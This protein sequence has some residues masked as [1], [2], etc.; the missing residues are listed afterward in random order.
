MTD[1]QVQTPVATEDNLDT[2]F[3]NV[4]TLKE[5]I[6]SGK[7]TFFQGDNKFIRSEIKATHVEFLKENRLKNPTTG[8]YSIEPSDPIVLQRLNNGV[9]QIVDGNHR[10]KAILE[11]YTESDKDDSQF[12]SIAFQLY[13]RELSQ[14]EVLFLQVR[15]NDSTERHSPREIALAVIS[16]RNLLMS[17]FSPEELKSRKVQKT[18]SDKIKSVFGIKDSAI[19]NYL[20]IYENQDKEGYPEI[21]QM[22][23]NGELDYS[24]ALV[25]TQRAK[26]ASWNLTK[27]IE[28]FKSVNV[29]N[30]KFVSPSRAATVRWLDKYA[31]DFLKKEKENG[32]SEGEENGDSEGGSVK[33]IKNTETFTEKDMLD[34]LNGFL[35]DEFIPK[36]LQASGTDKTYKLLQSLS[37]LINQISNS[38]NADKLLM[39]TINYLK[40]LIVIVNESEEEI[41][42]SLVSSITAQAIQVHKLV[43]GIDKKVKK[44]TK[45]A[46]KETKKAKEAADDKELPSASVTEVEVDANNELDIESLDF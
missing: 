19:S 37:L 28:N 32:G 29:F 20:A 30:N 12:G 33:E 43:N 41:H 16:Y 21:I 25:I 31:D 45:K 6:D 1:L 2:Q 35:T 44:E 18:I 36:A 26:G 8:K 38:I 10:V 14:E 22:I 5:M 3:L 42:P 13:E 34:E 46:K 27:L 17:T 24:T 9:E 7:V 39:L 4:K 11:A 15:S 40:E 23:D